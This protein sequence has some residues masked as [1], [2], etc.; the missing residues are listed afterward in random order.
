MPSMIE[1]MKSSPSEASSSCLLKLSL[2]LAEWWSAFVP[3]MSPS[4]RDCA[5]AGNEGTGG[6]C[7]S[8][9]AEEGGEASAPP[10]K[11][12]EALEDDRVLGILGVQAGGGG[13]CGAC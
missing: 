5:N 4:L 8:A 9:V 12:E 6:S 13:I 11:G 10:V 1:S 7:G 2:S 3:P